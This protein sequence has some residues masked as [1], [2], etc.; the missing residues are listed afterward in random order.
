MSFPDLKPTEQTLTPARMDSLGIDATDVRILA[1]VPTEWHVTREEIADRSG[2]PY[3]TV[4]KR[5]DNVR[6]WVETST[7]TTGEYPHHSSTEAFRREVDRFV[8]DLS[9]VDHGDS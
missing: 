8:I 5:I 6:E 4:C 2:V 7:K 3:P 1:S 9:T